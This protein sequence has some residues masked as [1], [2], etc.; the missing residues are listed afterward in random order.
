MQDAC[1][2]KGLDGDGAARED[3]A[4]GDWNHRGGTTAGEA[5]RLA[6]DYHLARRGREEEKKKTGVAIRCLRCRKMGH[7]ARDCRAPLPHQTPKNNR[8]SNHKKDLKDVECFNCGQKGHYSSNCPDRSM[9]CMERHVGPQGV[10]DI[11]KTRGSV[12]GVIQLKG[13][14]YQISSL[15]RNM[16]HEGNVPKDKLLQWGG[17][18]DTLRAWQHSIISN[19]SGRVGSGWKEGHSGSSSIKD[20]TYCSSTGNRCS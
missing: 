2:D 15:I 18:R 14:R 3:T 17:N 16:V 12:L 6:D 1:R 7:I 19:C 8:K 5:A 11:K 20:S 4:G 13:N 10:M 9:F